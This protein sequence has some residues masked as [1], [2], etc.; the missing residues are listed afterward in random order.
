[1]KKNIWIMNHYAT[2]MF[3][4]KGGRHY[5]FANELNK[6]G[7]DVTVF[8]ATTYLN[9]TDVV[10]TDGQLYI[11]KKTENI[12]F[13]FVRTH[14]SVGNGI[15]R[16]LNMYLFYHNLIP[17]ALRYAKKN[18]KPDVIIASSVHPLTMVAGIR[19]AKKLHVPCICEIRD[20][21]PEAIFSFGKVKEKSL[22]GKLLIR[23][24]H[25]IYRKARALIF[26]KEGDTD[27]LK[28][29]G[30]TIEQGGDI[31][32]RKCYYINNGIDLE[33]YLNQIDTET[34]ED[35]D[36]LNNKFNVMYTGTIRP[37][38]NVGNLLDAAKIISEKGYEQIQFLIY[39]DG[40]QRKQLEERIIDEKIRNVTFKGVSRKK[41]YS[42]YFEQIQCEF[43]ELFSEPVQLDQR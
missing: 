4:N 26:T 35:E 39:G 10:D 9:K 12:P 20:L 6:R 32:L 14:P 16:V 1:M 31:D 23:G 29:R 33:A 24:E 7:N 21:W 38:N 41:V 18:G 22:L 37:V 34:L 43:V 36:L 19:I 8:C 11:V 2:D 40:M 28:E 27:Y 17:T 13:V 3:F 30:W 15:D 25:W 5:W 42:I